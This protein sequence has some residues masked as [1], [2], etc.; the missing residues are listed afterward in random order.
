[1]GILLVWQFLFLHLAEETL[2][3]YNGSL[4]KIKW[5]ALPMS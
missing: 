5:G 3:E 1:M 2:S 4:V